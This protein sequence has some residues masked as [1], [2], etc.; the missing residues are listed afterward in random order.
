MTP[1]DRAAESF[2]TLARL[3]EVQAWGD[4]HEVVWLIDD[5]RAYLAEQLVQAHGEREPRPCE[6]WVGAW[7]PECQRR[8]A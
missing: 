5:V 8:A 7:E 4:G 3:I 6:V 1:V 2:D